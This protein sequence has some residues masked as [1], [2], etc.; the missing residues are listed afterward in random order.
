MML[1][2]RQTISSDIEHI[3]GSK[4]AKASFENC[5]ITIGM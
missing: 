5:R 3:K 1:L 4:K 2:E